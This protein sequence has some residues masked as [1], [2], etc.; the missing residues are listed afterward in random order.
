LFFHRHDPA[1][2]EKLLDAVHAQAPQLPL[3]TSE[4]FH[5]FYEPGAAPVLERSDFLLANVHP[6]FQPWFQSASAGDAAQFVVN[7][8]SKL[9]GSYCGPI[10]VKE[11]GIP[12]APQAK[13]FTQERQA[14]FYE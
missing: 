1:E 9:A 2:L 12:T 8:V 7:V 13:G 5:I 3:A 14:L 4:P 10:L 6:I 11:T